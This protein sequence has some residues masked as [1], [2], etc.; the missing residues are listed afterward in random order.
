MTRPRTAACQTPPYPTCVPLPLLHSLAALWLALLCGCSIKGFALRQVA[1]ALTAPGGGGL[2][3]ESD[4]EL[5]RDAAPFGL[6]TL[7][8]LVHSLPEHQGLHLSLASGFV[9]YTYG[10][11]QQEA[12]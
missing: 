8:Q 5:A 2:A 4:P 12:D 7:E 6:K 1:D 9:Q 10:F 3:E 11:V